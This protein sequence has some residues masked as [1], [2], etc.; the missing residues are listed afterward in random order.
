MKLT[1]VAH[2]GEKAA[3]WAELIV[4]YQTALATELRGA[5][6]PYEVSQV[7]ATI[8]GLE[9]LP[10]DAISGDGP[11]E[12]PWRLEGVAELLNATSALP[13]Q[14]RIGGYRPDT[15]YPFESFGRHP[16]L[17]SFTV[18]ASGLVVAIGWPEAHG[19]FSNVLDELRREFNPYGFVHKYHK[20]AQDIDNDFFFVLGKIDPPAVVDI[21]IETAAARIRA[22]MADAEPVYV[23]VAK[24]DLAVIA[25]VDEELPAATSQRIR[26]PII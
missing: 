6:R 21:D 15:E 4:R 11:T 23:Q 10:R 22:C 26:L 18:H 25:Y 13:F 1:L 16:F 17:R 5:F 2:Y 9:G 24:S 19:T 20:T 3:Q 12:T 14:V 7:H 8:I